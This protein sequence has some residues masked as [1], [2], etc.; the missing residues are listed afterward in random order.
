[1]THSNLF[2]RRTA[3]VA[4]IICYMLTGGAAWA[5]DMKA[6]VQIETGGQGPMTMDYWVTDG[7]VRIDLMQPQEISIVLTSGAAPKMLMIQHADRSYMEMPEQMLG[8]MRQMS[9]SAGGGDEPNINIDDLAFEPTGQTETI[10]AWTA[11]GVRVTGMDGAESTI[12]ISG[13]V[14]TGLFELFAEM[15]DALQA[16]QGPMFG[17]TGGPQQQMTRYREMRNAAGLP[18]GGVV[19]M[20]VDNAGGETVITLRALEQGTFG[21]ALSAPDGYQGMQMPNIIGFPK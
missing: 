10:G 20:N 13:D 8:M 15:G 19:R 14:D 18:D 6:T 1:M 16:M 9:K 3:L 12:W 17:G 11:S 21:D 2:A 5:E 4:A 7:G